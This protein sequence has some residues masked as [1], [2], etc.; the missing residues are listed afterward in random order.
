GVDAIGVRLEK[1]DYRLR[2]GTAPNRVSLRGYDG[3]GGFTEWLCTRD[4]RLTCRQTQKVAPKPPEPGSGGAIASRLGSVQGE[5]VGE[6]QC[7]QELYRVPASGAPTTLAG[8]LQLSRTGQSARFA[9]ATDIPGTI[10]G[11][12]KINLDGRDVVL[13][14]TGSPGVYQGG[15]V[16]MTLGQRGQTISDNPA[17]GYSP[18]TVTLAIGG[19]SDSFDAVDYGGC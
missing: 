1:S 2:N 6:A 3:Y 12:M 16:T 5:A 14:P 11:G 4:N 13:A 19:Q 15:G 18:L 17:Y 10:D 8:M 9:T 7:F